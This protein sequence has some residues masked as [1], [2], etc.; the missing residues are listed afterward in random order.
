MKARLR[1]CLC[2][3]KCY[4]PHTGRENTIG[5]LESSKFHEIQKTEVLLL[6]QAVR[7][8]ATK[9]RYFILSQYLKITGLVGLLSWE[10]ERIATE[11]V[12]VHFSDKTE[13]R[14]QHP[15]RL[16]EVA[17]Y[18]SVSRTCFHSYSASAGRMTGHST[19][20]GVWATRL[21]AA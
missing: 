4:Y 14:S 6:L 5:T 9:W 18:E 16:A 7:R 3:R 2:R 13:S 21:A 17:L 10:V 15:A 1:H 12:M 8:D 11:K 19:Q 20:E